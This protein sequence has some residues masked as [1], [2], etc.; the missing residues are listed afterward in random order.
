MSPVSFTGSLSG[1][2]LD[3][4]TA[5]LLSSF[6]LIMMHRQAARCARALS[7]WSK[8]LVHPSS[9]VSICARMGGVGW[10]FPFLSHLCASS[11]P[12]FA[13]LFFLPIEGVTHAYPKAKTLCIICPFH[14]IV[15]ILLGLL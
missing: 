5:T 3:P 15:L 4:C 13:V 11:G 8:W 10:L 7:K 6:A 2:A 1:S 9:A 12:S 14:P